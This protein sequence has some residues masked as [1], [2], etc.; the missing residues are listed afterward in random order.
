MEREYLKS[1]RS[2][3]QDAPHEHIMA[4]FAWKQISILKFLHGISQFEEPAS[5]VTVAVITSQEEELNFT[6]SVQKDE[7]CDEIFTN[8]LNESFVIA[9]GDLRKLY[10]LRPQAVD[11]M[12]FGHFIT[13][14]HRKRPCQPAVIDPVS[15]V[16]GESGEMIVGSEVSAPLFIKLSNTVIMKKRS[17]KS[18]PVPLLLRSNTL[19]SYGERMLFQPWR[20]VGELHQRQ[21]E[22]EKEKQKQNLLELFPMAIFLAGEESSR[23]EEQESCLSGPGEVE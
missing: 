21:S 1:E 5:Q 9:N 4:G 14:Y 18:K 6:E 19:D 16:G 2:F 7:E 8:S 20:N 23:S 15:G 11:E 17:E 22:E 12:P 10:T 13:D 3:F